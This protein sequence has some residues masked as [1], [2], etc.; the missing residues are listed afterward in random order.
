MSMRDTD[1]LVVEDEAIVALH[2][3]Q[4]LTKL[5][6][7]IA[8]VA[9]SGAEALRL[10]NEL[11]PAI[12]LMD[13]NIDGDIDGIE[14][15]S[16]LSPQFGPSVVYVS[17]YAEEPT[18]ERARSTGPY[19]YLVKPFSERELH[20]TIQMT[21]ERRRLDAELRAAQQ[22]AQRERDA[23]QD[24]LKIATVRHQRIQELQGELAHAQRLTE[25]GQVVTSLVHEVS[26]PIAA[27]KNYLGGLKRMTT[28]DKLSAVLGRIDEQANRTTA[29]IERLRN[30]LRKQD[31]Q[32]RQEPLS[33][34]VAEAIALTTTMI[35]DFETTISV[36]LQP[37]EQEVEVD[38]VLI[39]QVLV[40]LIRNG[41][42][43]VQDRKVRQVTVASRPTRDNM[44]EISVAD[45]GP[46]VPDQIRGKLF[47][48]FVTTK[49]DGM[50]VGLS[51]CHR[52]IEMHSGKLWV[53]DGAAGG[54]VFRF[55]VSGTASPRHAKPSNGSSAG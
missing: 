26:Q 38:K 37:E 23:A 27:I 40:N 45:T 7:S 33:Q 55:T 46:G 3:R 19:G 50:G 16:R 9:S 49:S 31:P 2:M 42:E 18:L 6:Y 21:L 15:A 34:I 13:I 1:V 39:Q 48:P 10:A 20:A 24:H 8:G 52:I 44:V 43:A 17:A 32:M 14:T 47:E 5:G 12:V 54:A 22:I 36:Q 51:T 4:Q 53:E 41:V 30:Y 11:H 25:L 35:T 29:I 28:S